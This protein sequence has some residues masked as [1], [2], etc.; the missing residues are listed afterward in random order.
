MKFL[1]LP[2]S[3]LLVSCGG[4][5]P[6]DAVLVGVTFKDQVQTPNPFKSVA[7]T[8][9]ENGQVAKTFT[10]INKVG[11]RLDPETFYSR[12]KKLVRITA[13]FP[14][15]VTPNVVEFVV[16]EYIQ[17]RSYS[18]QYKEMNDGSFT[19]TCLTPTKP[20]PVNP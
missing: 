19:V 13:Q 4:L 2:M 16:D 11:E 6:K 17:T 1:L 12:S 3:V 7:I 5:L 18:V 20:C 10:K 8:I 14:D 9:E 15:Q